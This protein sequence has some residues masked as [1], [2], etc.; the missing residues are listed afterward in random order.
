MM[1]MSKILC[2]VPIAKDSKDVGKYTQ[3]V[4]GFFFNN[5]DHGVFR[6]D[7]E[8]SYLVDESQGNYAFN[9]QQ[10]AFPMNNGGNETSSNSTNLSYRTQNQVYSFFNQESELKDGSLSFNNNEGTYSASSQSGSMPLMPLKDFKQMN[11][12][13]LQFPRLNSPGPVPK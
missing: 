8:G 11:Y 5:Q 9:K 2:P 3:K 12:S 6:N 7:T 4:G 1:L 13:S 10:G